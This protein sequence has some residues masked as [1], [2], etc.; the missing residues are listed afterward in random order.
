MPGS[1]SKTLNLNA[2][3]KYLKSRVNVPTSMGSAE[4]ALSSNFNERVR[5]HAFFSA[6]VAESRILDRL[7]HYSDRYSSGKIDKNSARAFLKSFLRGKGFSPDGAIT[8]DESTDRSITN[9]ASTSRLNLI[10][11][12]NKLM[13]TT[14]G[15][16]EEIRRLGAPFMRYVPSWKREKREEHKKFY[17]TILPVDHAFWDTHTPPLDFNCGCSIQAVWDED[18]AKTHGGVSDV[19]PIDIDADTWALKNNNG[20]FKIETPE[21]GFV[22]NSAAPFEEYDLGR[23]QNLKF[24]RAV[25]EEA[26]IVFGDQISTIKEIIKF[27]PENYKTWKTLGLTSAKKWK[28]MAVPAVIKASKARKVL[29]KGIQITSAD[30][31]MVTLGEEILKHWHVDGKKLASDIEGRLERLNWAI[32]TLETPQEIWQQKNQKGYLQIFKKSTGGMRG[33]LVFFFF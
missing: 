28:P 12:Q 13:A 5:A 19:K 17:N 23:I 6:K 22:F 1:P 8:D 30:G 14:I 33:C 26:E 7:R 31:S 29:E 24:R 32:A 25:V 20:G 16:K 3:S 9:L 21:S 10:L 11:N 4:I 2:K 18:E 27:S 15:K